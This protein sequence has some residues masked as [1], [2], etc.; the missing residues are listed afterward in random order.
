MLV[1]IAIATILNFRVAAQRAR[2]FK[3]DSIPWMGTQRPADAPAT[4]IDFGA[5]RGTCSPGR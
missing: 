4:G 2:I 5:A 1:T 3:R